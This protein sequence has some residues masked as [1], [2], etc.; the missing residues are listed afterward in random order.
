MKRSVNCQRCGGSGNYLHHGT[1]FRCDGAGLDP[2]ET[3]LVFAADWTPDEI[4]AFYDAKLKQAEARRVKREAKKALSAPDYLTANIKRSE[5]IQIV[6][7]Y[8]SDME[9]KGETVDE[10]FTN[11]IQYASERILDDFV[12][13]YLETKTNELLAA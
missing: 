1:C 3:E 6:I 9:S 10:Y 2:T 4:N 8:I 11:I 13:S 7:D 12:I 5:S